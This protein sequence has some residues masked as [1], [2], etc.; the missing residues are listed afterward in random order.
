MRKI[1]VAL[2][3]L[4]YSFV[5]N[6]GESQFISDKLSLS[7]FKNSKDSLLNSIPILTMLQPE[8]MDPLVRS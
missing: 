5:Q 3:L 2:F 7:D 8:D 4:F 6:N 1:C